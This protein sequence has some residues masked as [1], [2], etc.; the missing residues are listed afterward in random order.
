[1]AESP[2]QKYERLQHVVQEHILR[3]YPN[4]EREGCP[5]HAVVRSV[6]ARTELQKDTW[7]HHITHCS[8]CY[9]EFLD[10]RRQLESAVAEHRGVSRR[11]I[12][13]GGGAVALATA[14]AVAV[15]MLRSDPV[16]Q[17]S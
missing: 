7:W 12:I 16:Y 15:R 4:P 11:R 17:V 5:G 3:D 9:Q 6:A 13:V 8:P 14:S 2:K 10:E 1:M